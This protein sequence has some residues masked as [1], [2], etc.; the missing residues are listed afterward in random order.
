MDSSG[1]P[2]AQVSTSCR[3]GSG[4]TVAPGGRAERKHGR[5]CDTWPAGLISVTSGEV[6]SFSLQQSSF[7]LIA[8]VNKWLKDAG[9][10]CSLN[11]IEGI[12]VCVRTRKVK[13][14]QSLSRLCDVGGRSQQSM[15]SGLFNA[16][17]L[18]LSLWFGEKQGQGLVSHVTTI[19]VTDMRTLYV[20][21]P[22]Y[23]KVGHNQSHHN[24]PIPRGQCFSF[25][26]KTQEHCNRKP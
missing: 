3:E 17:G 15:S 13:G 21:F 25:D 2:P 24:Y 10:V 12:C 19:H 26:E 7:S 8:L 14:N 9:C 4:V 23:I 1:A 18:F 6:W 22:L 5:T 11:G 16:K 20:K